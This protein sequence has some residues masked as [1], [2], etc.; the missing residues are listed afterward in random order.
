MADC[1]KQMY[2]RGQGAS[3]GNAQHQLSQY[4]QKEND[5]NLAP[6]FRQCENFSDRHHDYGSTAPLQSKYANR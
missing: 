4:S 2:L 1:D 3:N 5:G 6:V